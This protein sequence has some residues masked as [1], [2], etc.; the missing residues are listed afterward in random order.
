MSDT[1]S[2]MDNKVTSPKAQTRPSRSRSLVSSAKDSI[3]KAIK[4]TSLLIHGKDSD[5]MMFEFR[6][7]GPV[8]D[9]S[10]VPED[11]VDSR[12]SALEESESHSLNKP[13]SN[14]SLKSNISTATTSNQLRRPYSKSDA[15]AKPSNAV[16][17]WQKAFKRTSH[18]LQVVDAMKSISGEQGNEATSSPAT[19]DPMLQA[20]LNNLSKKLPT[21]NDHE[22][23]RVLSNESV[24]KSIFGGSR[25]AA[26]LSNSALA[27]KIER[28][29]SPGSEK[30]V[31]SN[32]NMSKSGYMS[33]GRRKSLSHALSNSMLA[34][35]SVQSPPP[36]RAQ[37]QEDPLMQAML[38]NLSKKMPDAKSSDHLAPQRLPSKRLSISQ[39]FSN[40][41]LILSHS[42][43]LSNHHIG[44]E[45]PR[46][47]S[48]E[49]DPPEK[50][51]GSLGRR[52]RGL[53]NPISTSYSQSSQDGPRSA[54]AAMAVPA[55]DNYAQKNEAS[56]YEDPALAPRTS[57]IAKKTTAARARTTRE[58][59]VKEVQKKRQ[60]RV[61]EHLT[62]FIRISVQVLN[63]PVSF[64]LVVDTRN[65]I[66]YLAQQIEAEFAYRN[67]LDSKCNGKTTIP[68][69]CSMLYDEDMTILDYEHPIQGALFMNSIVKV[70]NDYT[71]RSI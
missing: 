54:P 58:L 8:D 37:P 41:S 61:K 12:V 17:N 27:E 10:I 19:A 25:I 34:G 49:L 53:S 39:L 71:G 68:L 44:P 55:T 56:T 11:A 30:R 51:H 4:R 22:L 3:S 23:T 6:V 45:K 13:P 69:E 33:P 47:M 24:A 5:P 14:E 60:S 67:M 59:R 35:K 32:E 16:S 64:P 15:G 63:Q 20:M 62:H 66:E 36:V 31:L 42:N 2:S 18:I 57:K 43:L 7:E 48:D 50:K 65:T 26:V 29:S 28:P 9:R 40:P 1:S 21:N 52:N 70:K 38:D 46:V